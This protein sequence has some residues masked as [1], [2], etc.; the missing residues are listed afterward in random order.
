MSLLTVLSQDKILTSSELQTTEVPIQQN[1]A[2]I[3][4]CAFLQSASSRSHSIPLGNPAN[5]AATVSCIC[6]NRK[7]MKYYR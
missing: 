6:K 4:Y 7:K 3:H 5:V 2:H 1:N